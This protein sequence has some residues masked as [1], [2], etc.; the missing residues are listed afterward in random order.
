MIGAE[1]AAVAVVLPWQLYRAWRITRDMDRWD[2]QE[3][4]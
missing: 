1:I 4:S 3:F 2:D